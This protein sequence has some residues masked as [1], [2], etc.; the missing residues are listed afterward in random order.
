MKIDK[1]KLRENIWFLSTQAESALD[2]FHLWQASL[3][4]PWTFV[5]DLLIA[6]A[7]IALGAWAWN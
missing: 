6:A 3:P 4:P 1:Q 7:L 2:R 5:S